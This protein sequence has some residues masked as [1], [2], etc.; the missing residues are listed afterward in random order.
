MLRHFYYIMFPS[1]ICIFLRYLTSC[2]LIPNSEEIDD[3]K[4]S[5]KER[6]GK[7]YHFYTVPRLRE[8][9]VRGASKGNPNLEGFGGSTPL[10]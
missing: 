3:L 1:H 9:R 2:F 8:Q 10:P 4:L 6:C 5:P 7:S